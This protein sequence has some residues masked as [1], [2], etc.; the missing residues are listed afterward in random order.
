M[1]I[2]KLTAFLSQTQTAESSWAA[3]ISDA[4]KKC[5]KDLKSKTSSLH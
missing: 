3:S 1:D 5:D 2:G 4:I